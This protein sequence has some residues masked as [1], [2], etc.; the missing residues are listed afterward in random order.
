ME[1]LRKNTDGFRFETYDLFTRITNDLIASTAF[2]LETHS[3]KDKT[4]E[5]Y[6]LGRKL[7]EFSMA[8]FFKWM[9]FSVAPG[10]GKV[11]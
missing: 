5:F 10:I 8:F 11:P 2:G 1:K 9:F 4:N 7:N 6:K 3:L